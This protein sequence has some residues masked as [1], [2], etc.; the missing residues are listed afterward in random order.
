MAEPADDPVQAVAAALRGCSSL[1]VDDIM[2]EELV[3]I[4]ETV[5]KARDEWMARTGYIPEHIA[6]HR[7]LLVEE[8][9]NPP[10]VSPEKTT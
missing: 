2:E 4:A 3:E 10:A 7:W 1:L 6:R 5:I 9:L 8:L